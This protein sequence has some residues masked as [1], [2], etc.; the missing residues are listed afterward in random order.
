MVFLHVKRNVINIAT[1]ILDRQKQISVDLKLFQTELIDLIF[2]AFWTGCILSLDR[3][4][5][6]L[7]DL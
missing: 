1:V 4:Y 2:A 7:F 5:K 3:R 6:A